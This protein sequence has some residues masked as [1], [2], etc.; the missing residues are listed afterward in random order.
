MENIGALIRKKRTD[1]NMTQLEL[2]NRLFVS[3]K[4]V[5]KW[6]TGAGIPDTK[7]LPVIAE[8]L[9]IDAR[10]LISGSMKTNKY[11]NGNLKKVRFYMCPV[12]KNIIWQIGEA[13]IG[14]C[15]EKLCALEAKPKDDEH[16]VLVL[17]DANEYLIESVHEMTKEHYI[18]F[19]AFVTGD[20]AVVKKLYPEQDMT[21][22][23]P[24][25]ARGTLFYMCIE[26]G[27]FYKNV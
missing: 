15:A 25:F 4:T 19:A 24:Y 11:V 21:F 27:L 3:D 22:R 18:C 2:S 17:K 16:S 26:H 8:T 23:L 1:K 7:M 10:S 13:N 5:S 12:C 6:E 14:C 20:C 9:G